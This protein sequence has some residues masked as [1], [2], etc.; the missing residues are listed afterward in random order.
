MFSVS[1]ALDGSFFRVINEDSNLLTLNFA[2]TIIIFLSL[3]S[4]EPVPGNQSIDQARYRRRQRA[5]RLRISKS[6][7]HLV[8]AEALDLVILAVVESVKERE[9]HLKL[10][11][12]DDPGDFIG[13]ILV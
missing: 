9:R 6:H 3:S 8:V 4:H 12:F 13:P 7:R 10:S 5:R 11:L 1:Y 2:L